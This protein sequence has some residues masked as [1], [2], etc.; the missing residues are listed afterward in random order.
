MNIEEKIE[1]SK[2]VYEG[3]FINVE[4]LT[5]TLPDGRKGERDVV[6]HP[7]AVAVLALNDNGDILMERQYRVP[8]DQVI[9][10][11]PAGKVDPD[12]DPTASAQRELQEETGYTAG[13]ILRV[14]EII[15]AAGY[16]DEI[17]EIF[18]ARD[19]TLGESRMDED[20][21]LEHEFIPKEK[22]LQMIKTGEIKDSKTIC[23]M[24]YLQLQSDS[25]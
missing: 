7:G 5:V 10:E 14:G 16:S 4:R 23:A 1:D 11:I 20:E 24:L 9:Y 12:E 6:R 3:V 15:L 22:V 25:I 18:I 2:V 8:I 17:I 13:E 19:L 21:F